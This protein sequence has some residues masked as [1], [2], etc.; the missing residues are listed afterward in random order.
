MAAFPSWLFM[1]TGE[2]H[3]VYRKPTPTNLYMNAE[4]HHHPNNE[5]LVLSTL[6]QR[7]SAICNQESL[8]GG[9]EFLHST[10]KQNGY[11]DR[12]IHSCSQS[13]L[14]G[15]HIYRTIDISG[16]LT[17]CGTCLQPHQQGANET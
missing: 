7:T 12:H 16:L 10:F 9:L 8:P 6:V 11:I 4:S 17:L 14:Q 2:Q 1:Y 15:G 13:T 5:Y 3:T